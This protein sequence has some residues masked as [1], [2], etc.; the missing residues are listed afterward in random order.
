MRPQSEGQAAAVFP[1]PSR[2]PATL[3]CTIENNTAEPN[4]PRG[5]WTQ[6]SMLGYSDW[7]TPA[8]FCASVCVLVFQCV[9][10]PLTTPSLLLEH[11]TK[12]VTATFLQSAC[13]FCHVFSNLLICCLPRACVCACV[14]VSVRGVRVMSPHHHWQHKWTESPRTFTEP[15]GKGGK[16]W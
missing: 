11:Q 16:I 8:V 4:N 2:G 9:R 15:R 5:R 13:L 3:Q 14:C 10:S 1:P 12:Q 7:L 6:F